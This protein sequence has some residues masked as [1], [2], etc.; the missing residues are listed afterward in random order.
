VT[1]LYRT[2]ITYKRSDE[3]FMDAAEIRYARDHRRDV[4]RMARI[5]GIASAVWL[6]LIGVCWLTG[7]L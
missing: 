5:F 2:L 4:D 1:L 7:V 3:L 6:V